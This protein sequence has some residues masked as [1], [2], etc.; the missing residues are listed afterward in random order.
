[1]DKNQIENELVLRVLNSYEKDGIADITRKE[2]IRCTFSKNVFPRILKSLE[3]SKDIENITQQGLCL[4]YKILTKLECPKFLLMEDFSVTMK[5]YLL[6]GYNKLENYSEISNKKL[7]EIFETTAV[8]RILK[9]FQNESYFEVLRAKS[10]DTKSS[11][12]GY[13]IVPKEGGLALTAE[14]NVY[15]KE[16][17]CSIC[18]CL[19]SSLF[20]ENNHSICK[21]CYNKRQ[22][23]KYLQDMKDDIGKWLYK[24]C[25]KGYNKRSKIEEINVT[26]EFLEDL[27]KEQNGLCYY[28]G[29]PFTETDR[30]SVDR[31]DSS[32][33]YIQGNVVICKSSINFMKQEFTIEQFK[34]NII[35]L[36]NN[37]NN[38]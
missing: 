15:N 22:R 12:T 34:Q 25:E 6:L 3:A 11:L 37:I 9:L 26:P 1:M 5:K 36:Y 16:Y 7:E 4:R 30:P 2:L 14:S 28:T 23:E 27:Y 38:F 29:L 10:D 33:G 35:D 32:K 31:I 24:K 19:D 13:T 17:K 21:E 8:S 20:Y 18:G